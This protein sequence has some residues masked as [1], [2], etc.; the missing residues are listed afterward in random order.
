MEVS[1]AISATIRS[2]SR[3]VTRS[4]PHWAMPVAT[5]SAP[6]DTALSGFWISVQEIRLICTT[7]C[8]RK[9]MN[10][11][12]KLVMIKMSRSPLLWFSPLRYFGKS[13]TVS[14]SSLGL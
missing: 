8:T 2:K 13:T 6:P 3:I 1:G 7:E 11:L 5:L 14:T 9:A 4:S 12:L 10:I